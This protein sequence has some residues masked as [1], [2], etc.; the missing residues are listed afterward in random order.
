MARKY[1]REFKL[2]AIRRAS[3]EGSTAVEVERRLGISQGVISRWK[4]QL[5]DKG[6]G[7]FPGIG[8]LSDRDEEFRRLQRELGRVTRERDI[9]KK[10]VSIFSESR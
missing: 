3:E 10:A 4:K 8:H 9:V 6:G 2:E 1:D 7:A 5:K